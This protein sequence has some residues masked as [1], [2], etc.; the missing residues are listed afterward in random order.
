MIDGLCLEGLSG[1]LGEFKAFEMRGDMLRRLVLVSQIH[2][3]SA[4]GR[5]TPAVAAVEVGVKS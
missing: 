5:R 2:N 4:L 3:R 1:K